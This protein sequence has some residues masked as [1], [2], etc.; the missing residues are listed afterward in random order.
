MRPRQTLRRARLCARAPSK[1]AFC[2]CCDR[3]R[4]G[5]LKKD[6]SS[7]EIDSQAVC[8][9]AADKVVDDTRDTDGKKLSLK[10]YRDAYV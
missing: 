5:H 10:K 2:V 1:G 9:N 4:L 6:L 8:C 3:R 7:T